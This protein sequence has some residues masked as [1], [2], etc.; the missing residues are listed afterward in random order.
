M[1]DRISLGVFALPCSG[2][3][4]LI[5]V[6]LPGVFINPS[7]D[8]EGFA[9][10]SAS[11]GVGNMLGIVSLVLWLVGIQSLY[12]FLG[13]DA[14]RQVGTSC[15]GLLFCRNRA[16]LATGRNLSLRCTCRGSSLLER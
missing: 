13:G 7:V 8:P 15:F 6:L 3:L 10:A 9:R 5:S 11:I 4:G 16:F 14:G 12:S 1:Q 2:L